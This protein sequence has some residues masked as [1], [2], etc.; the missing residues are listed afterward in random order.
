MKGGGRSAFARDSSFTRTPAQ[1]AKKLPARPNSTHDL[2][3]PKSSQA[4]SKH[5][6]EEAGRRERVSTILQKRR[7]E[8]VDLVQAYAT[9][10]G[11]R[12]QPGGINKD[13][14]LDKGDFKQITQAFGIKLTP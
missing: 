12:S 6:A 4:L 5:I 7:D 9:R 13:T 8:F 10:K 3:Q 14:A 2:E 11:G 1:R